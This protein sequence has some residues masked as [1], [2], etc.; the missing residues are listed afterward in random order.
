[1]KT[2]HPPAAT[3]RRSPRLLMPMLL[4]GNLLL[5]SFY[6]GVVSILLPIQ[7]ENIDAS[8]KETNLG[9][10]TGIGA[11]V[12]TLFNPIGGALSDRTR[13]RFGRRNPYLLGGAV[14]ALAFAAVMG[15]AAVV[16]LLVVG[17]CLAQ[18][19]GNVYQAALTA[20]VPDRIPA[21]RRGSASAI[22]GIGQQGG[23]LLGIVLAGRFTESIL[24]G[25]LVLGALLVVAAV[26]MTVLTHD[27]RPDE[28]PD[29]R[30]RPGPRDD[31]ASFLSALRHDDFRWVFLGRALMIFGYFLIIGYMLYLLK[32]H[33]GVP[34]GV[35]PADGVALLMLVSTVTMVACTAVGGP[36][37]DRLDRRK[38]FVLVAGLG[39]A[40]SLLVPLFSPT[41]PAMLAFAALGGA[42]FGVYM[43]VDTAIVTLVLPSREDAA[44]DMGVLNIANA[45][46][47]IIA[48]FAAAL[49]IGVLGGYPSLFIVAA[50]A[51][52]AG[53]VAILPVKGVR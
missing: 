23:L 21:R 46:P 22:M 25:Y 8:A 13:T 50:V 53:A 20:I 33:I 27:P 36:L 15:A 26:L 30:A 32:D 7:V 4:I 9:V 39:S 37:S 42:F 45:G 31:L 47:Q 3:G 44:R 10:I 24:L 1:M 18:A 19:M 35:E 38:T 14:L 12:A 52:L 16:P 5:F 48:P 40:A 17:W 29:D 51:S 43:A 34:D 6:G 28:L 2:L 49:V 41:W 11:V